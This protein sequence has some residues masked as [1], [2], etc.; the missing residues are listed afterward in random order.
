MR[1]FLISLILFFI[2]SN[3]S[4]AEEINCCEEINL[5]EKPKT[6][7]V[8]SVSDVVPKG[9]EAKVTA[10]IPTY[11]KLTLPQAIDYALK[12]NLAIKSTRLDIDKSK[13]D[14]KTAGRFQNP[15]IQAFYNAGKAATD[16]PNNIGLIQPFEIAKRGPRKRF[17]QANLELTKGNVALKE[18]YLRLDVRQAYVDLV[19]AKS[20]LKIL[21]DQ[22][23]LLEELYFIAQ[24][25][26]EVGTAPEMD[27]IQAKMTL[28]QLITQV[29]TARTAVDVARYNFN[30]I[31]AATNY[32][33]AEDYLPDQ[34]D[35][36]FLL[37]PQPQDKMP[38]FMNI[39]NIAAD[40]RLDLKNA[41]QEV[42]VARKNLV[43]V[44]RQRVPDIELGGGIIFVPNSLAT[45]DYNTYGYYIASNIKNI[46]LVYLYRPEIKNA[47]IQIEQ[48]ILNYNQLRHEAFM[49][50]NSTYDQFVT[51]QTN[52]NY[53]N[54]AL[55][56]ESN[57]F[58]GMAKKSYEIG[59]TNISN[60]IFIQQS[61]KSIL[62]GYT[63]ALSTYY[64]SWVDFLR[65]VND[66]EIKLDEK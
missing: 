62:M 27:A 65:E 63:N 64:N 58:L 38:K 19:A 35:F 3:N 57:Q 48:K 24:K 20:V 53:Y 25:K 26:Y 12:N 9:F 66:E 40:K 33:T 28:D 4:F 23:I 45:V 6:P 22:K 31:L 39:A 50:L 52:L 37:T 54:D 55:L 16:N 49:D 2:I 42:E 56:T 43:L 36:V 41:K 29:N 11:T 18:F 44:L 13:N 15:Y 14:I 46:P 17:A 10:D 59:K 8:E 51:A 32:D 60:F 34:K 1:K 47:K 61:Y 7:I 21:E 30:K 5:P